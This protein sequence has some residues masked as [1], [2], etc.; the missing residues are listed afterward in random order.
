MFISTHTIDYTSA[1]RSN[2]SIV[3]E[4]RALGPDHLVTNPGSTTNDLHN[5]K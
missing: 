3:V 1:V 4:G 5:L 2:H